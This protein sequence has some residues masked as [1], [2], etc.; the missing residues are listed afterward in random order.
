[1]SIEARINIERKLIA[2]LCKTMREY[3]WQP[4]AV[5]N[6]EGLEVCDTDEE[7]LDHVFSVDESTIIFQQGVAGRR[8]RVFIVLGND[9]YD[10][11]CYYSYSEADDFDQ[12]MKTYV[13][14]YAEQL[15][16]GEV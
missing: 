15:E 3:G 2:H 6:G 12:I 7:I 9:G 13:D 5:D 1:M 4:H 8:H 10:A 14:P 16:N 11:I